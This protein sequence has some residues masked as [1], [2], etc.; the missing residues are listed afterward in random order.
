TKATVIR[1]ARTI[2]NAFFMLFSPP[3]LLLV[4]LSCMGTVY[5]VVV[6]LS[7]QIDIKGKRFGVSFGEAAIIGNIRL[8]N[9][10]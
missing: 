3:P 1:I 8:R 7:Q 9:A 2:I 10:L 6:P 5:A 4:T